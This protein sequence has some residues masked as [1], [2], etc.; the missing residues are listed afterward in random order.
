[1][2]EAVFKK[3]LKKWLQIVKIWSHKFLILG[4]EMQQI[5]TLFGNRSWW[6]MVP[7]CLIFFAYDSTSCNRLGA[8]KPKRGFLLPLLYQLLYGTLLLCLLQFWC[9]FVNVLIL[10]CIVIV[11][12]MLIQQQTWFDFFDFYLILNLTQNSHIF[13]QENAF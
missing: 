10:L 13:I 3:F 4:M 8:L 7:F 12:P 6:S 2:S 11:L 9:F 5:P 1:M